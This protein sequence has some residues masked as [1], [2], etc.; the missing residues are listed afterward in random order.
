[1][2]FAIPKSLKSLNSLQT[3]M[4]IPVEL[5]DLDVDRMLTRIMEMAVKL[6]RTA[7]S[8]TNTSAYEDYLTALQTN[9]AIVGFGDDRG[10]DTLDGWIRASVL[11]EER[12]GLRRDQVQMGYLRPL[13]VAGYRS[14][15]PKLGSR[16]RRAD[17]LTYR[18]VER[19]LAER[20]SSSAT[21]DIERLFLS[22]FGRGVDVGV[23]PWAVPRYDETTE[24]DIDT[25]LALRF[26]EGFEANQKNSTERMRLDPPVPLAIDPLGRDVIAL[27]E[28]FGPL[29]SESEAYLH[30]SAI[31]SLRLFQLPLIT[32]RT[33]RALLT[34]SPFAETTNPC[35]MYVDFTRQ[36]GSPSDLLSSQCVVRDLEIMRTFFRDRLLLRSLADAAST[37]E[38]PPVFDGTAAENLAKVAGLQDDP[39]VQHSLRYELKRIQD[40]LDEGTEDYAFV[41]QVRRSTVSSVDKFMQVVVEGLR[42]RGLENQVKW[43]YNAGGIRKS[44]GL[45]SGTVKARGTWRYAP[46]DE[47][48]V[49]LVNQCFVDPSGERSVIRLEF[50][51]LLERL[52]DRFGIVVDRPPSDLDSADARSAA[53]QN[54]EAFTRRLQLLG[55]FQGLSDDFNAQF[56]TRPREA[57]R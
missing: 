15:L 18:S 1:M 23:S 47:A 40:E 45:L 49:A 19:I 46:A 24:V 50:R 56:V 55:C 48:I 7:S 33:I 39:E 3:E 31:L 52:Q 9:P 20:G 28:L 38:H 42:K 37:M 43:F 44:Y 10:R 25:L 54:L 6:G 30:F 29:M 5:N 32:A 51:E 4:V 53:A 14:G 16:N 2:S 27:L 13:T 22:T 17:D 21:R 41:E 11:I 36:P 35:E 12:S 26:L 8:K 34:N 57:T